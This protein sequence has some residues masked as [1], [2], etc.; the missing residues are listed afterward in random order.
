MRNSSERSNSWLAGAPRLL[1]LPDLCD[2]P[3]ARAGGDGHHGGAALPLFPPPPPAALPAERPASRVWA[4]ARDGRGRGAQ[5]AALL[6][7]A[8][9]T[10]CVMWQVQH[11]AGE[12]PSNASPPAP[13][14]PP[15]PPL[16]R[17]ARPRRSRCRRRTTLWRSLRAACTSS[18]TDTPRRRSRCSGCAKCCW[19]RA[20]STRGWTKWCVGAGGRHVC[21]PRVRAWPC[22]PCSG[23]VAHLC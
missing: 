5:A 12:G 15:L 22:A 6:P 21:R 18:W 13:S 7:L 2:G 20:S 23:R 19:S 11:Q 8:A 9:C 3:G 10:W 16:H 1:R 17:P 14:S 4:A